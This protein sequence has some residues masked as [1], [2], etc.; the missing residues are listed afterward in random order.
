LV[1]RVAL[2]VNPFASGVSDDALERVERELAA[3]AHVTT[4]RTERARHATEL[5][6]AASGDGF[7]AIVGFSGDGGYNEMLNGL[8]AGLPVGFVPGGGTSVLP[9]ALGLPRDPARAARQI[10]AALAAGRSRPISL[11]RVNG[12]RFA[13]GAGVGFDAAV[14]RKVDELGRAED[15]RRPGDVAF[16]RAI[17]SVIGENGGRFAPVLEIKGLGRAGFAVVANTDPTTYA[18][19]LGLHFAPAARFELGL[20]VAAPTEVHR[21]SIP[22]LFFA[23]FTGRGFDPR[24]TL[25]GHDLDRIEIVCDRPL[26]LQADGE[27]LGDVTE[28]V[29]ECER[30]AVAVLA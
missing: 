19:R 11:G 10:A 23:A 16:L 30:A 2:I 4:L 25:Y 8:R 28:A 14:V 13:F 27:D 29:F 5:A 1:K 17:F 24:R 6:Q 7:D 21:R 12:W 9:R 15:G 20:D 18:G 22:R 26:P 3:T